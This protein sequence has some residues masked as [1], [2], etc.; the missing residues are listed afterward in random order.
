MLFEKSSKNK[1]K[2]YEYV[3]DFFAYGYIAL[4]F[5]LLFSIALTSVA[6][7]TGDEIKGVDILNSLAQIA[8]ALAFVF[9][10]FQYRKNSDKERQ[11]IIAA[12]AKL[13]TTRMAEV[14]DKARENQR[15]T[16]EDIN[17]FT[18]LMSNLG[19]DFMA[20]Y[21]ALTDDIHKAMVRM[22]WQDMHYNH[23]SKTLRH[24]TIDKLF[25]NEGLEKNFK[26][27]SFYNSRID[28]SIQSKDKVFQEYFFSLKVLNEMRIGDEIVS[29]VES[30][31]SFESYYFDNETT[32][33]LMY[34]LL[35]RLNFKVSAPFLAAIKEKK[36]E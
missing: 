17:S 34:G 33:D 21:E 29:K 14:A 7:I 8:T 24:Y 11:N 9:A 3:F 2:R 4:I 30:L 26:G 36:K 16:I 12:E 32:N 23:L 35:S 15:Y 1:K 19:C 18:I 20:I 5:I 28:S 25:E 31:S 6:S 27:Y 13:L 10:V 22:R